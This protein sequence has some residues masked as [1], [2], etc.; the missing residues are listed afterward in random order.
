MGKPKIC[1]TATTMTNYCVVISLNWTLNQVQK[2]SWP[3]SKFLRRHPPRITDEKREKLLTREQTVTQK[4]NWALLPC[5]LATCPLAFHVST[6]RQKK[7]IIVSHTCYASLDKVES[8]HLR[9]Q[10]PQPITW[11]VC[12]IRYRPPATT[13][14]V[15]SLVLLPSTYVYPTQPLILLKPAT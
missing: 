3:I 8:L 6:K 14:V 10:R 2:L 1:R 12:R 7:I 13:P 5:R 9:S 4:R 11:P 15:L